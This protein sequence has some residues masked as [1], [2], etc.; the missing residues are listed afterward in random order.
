[1]SP[2]EAQNFERALDGV[3]QPGMRHPVLGIEIELVGP[4]DLGRRGRKRLA[5]PVGSQRE[6]RSVDDVRVTPSPRARNP[7]P[8]LSPYPPRTG[9][10]D[11]LEE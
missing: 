3:D 1:M 8:P 7:G 4:V 6:V 9:V 2:F 11:T 5:H 10:C